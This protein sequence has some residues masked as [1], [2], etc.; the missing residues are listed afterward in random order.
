MSGFLQMNRDNKEVMWSFSPEQLPIKMA[1]AQEFASGIARAL[2]Y[3]D[4]PGVSGYLTRL[5]VTQSGQAFP[6]RTLYQNL[7][8]NGHTWAYFYNDSAWNTFIEWFETPQGQAGL[9]TYD[10]FYDQAEKGTLP[11][12]SFILPRQGT[13]TTTGKDVSLSRELAPVTAAPDADTANAASCPGQ[14]SND[15]HPCHDVALGERL[16]KDTYEALRAGAG[17]NKTLFLVTYDDAGGFYDHSP[18]PTR[19][20]PPPDDIPSCSNPTKFDFLGPRLPTLIISPWV[21]KGLVIH[22]PWGEPGTV[23]RPFE[24]SQF[25]H[26]SIAATVKALFGLPDFLTRRDAWAGTFHMALNLTRPREDTP[27]HL[28]EAPEPSSEHAAHSCVP[29]GELSRRHKRR[30]EFYEHLHS[31]QAPKG[32][33]PQEAEAWILQQEQAHRTELQNKFEL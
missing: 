26:S 19:D 2:T 33:E 11:N 6:Q 28:P 3:S 14:G 5:I 29:P 9:H 24:S 32:M 17:W 1:L 8:D 4:S 18:L 7:E 12:F 27:Y 16:L 10:T 13:N 22:E 21:P 30:I 23:V 25:E 20:V 15:D 31:V